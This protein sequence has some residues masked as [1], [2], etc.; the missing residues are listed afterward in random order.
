MKVRLR[1]LILG[2]V[3]LTALLLRIWGLRLSYCPVSFDRDE[4]ALVEK[5]DILSR[6]EILLSADLEYY[7]K[8]LAPHL[9]MYLIA[10]SGRVYST[11]RYLVLTLF[12][13]RPIAAFS[14]SGWFNLSLLISALAGAGSVYLVYL[15]GR[16]WG[17]D[18]NGLLSAL[19]F[20]VL[21]LHVEV[22]HM[23]RPHA[24]MVFFICLSAFFSLRIIQEG[25]GRDYLFS[26]LFGVLAAG[27]HYGATVVLAAGL[28]AHLE[29][30]RRDR[31]KFSRLILS[32][33]LAL[34]VGGALIGFLIA[35]PFLIDRFRYSLEMLPFYL[36]NVSGFGLP[37]PRFYRTGFNNLLDLGN[38]LALG[39]GK[40]GIVL[41]LLALFGLFR[42]CLRRKGGNS[43]LGSLV[44]L[45]L[46]VITFFLKKTD[47]AEAVILAPF[48]CLFAAGMALSA[49][50]RLIERRKFGFLLPAAAV[51]AIT[52]FLLGK[53]IQMDYF[54]WLPDTRLLAS[55][56]L[57][58]NIPPGSR[59]ALEDNI[60]GLTECG[61]EV[62]EFAAVHEAVLSGSRLRNYDFL[63]TSSF[64]SGHLI[65]KSGGWL[66]SFYRDLQ[67]NWPR[68]KVFRT[69]ETE[70]ANPV[71]TV[72]DFRDWGGDRSQALSI[73]R[74]FNFDYS[75][76][77]PNIVI[78]ADNLSRE[79]GSGFWI[80]EGEKINRLFIAPASLDLI[81]VGIFPTGIDE[82]LA[83]TV[84]GERKLIEVD[85]YEPKLFML[86][87]RVAFP[88]IDYSYRV[89]VELIS[90]RDALVKIITA[91]GQLARQNR[92]LKDPADS[93][94]YQAARRPPARF[95]GSWSRL[96]SIY[97]G[98]TNF[99][100]EL[101]WARRRYEF[102]REAEDGLRTTGEIIQDP[103]AAGNRAVGFFPDRHPSGYLLL[104]PGIHLPPRPWVATFRM[105]AANRSG[106]GNIAVIDVHIRNRRK[107][108][109]RRILTA[110][111]FPEQDRY[112]E[113]R[114]PFRNGYLNN[115][116]EF[117]VGFGEEQEVWCDRVVVSP[118]PVAWMEDYFS[119][120]EDKSSR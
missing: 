54:F 42:S 31:V 8:A 59:L 4:I 25:R 34:L 119:G 112:Y 115:L 17:G 10:L 70:N 99:I 85:D 73:L 75:A 29:N 35:F 89:R 72:Y 106:K 93:G 5:A 15:M 61:L 2:V 56:W 20:A 50:R 116:L 18:R 87:P 80:S 95:S 94:E 114:L 16:R 86:R 63:I 6:G 36:R 48:V 84:G 19:F 118:D 78:L 65:G 110:K 64:V 74:D 21:P 9:P 105:K 46:L 39:N 62:E 60:P 12:S 14:L 13:A 40:A 32:K 1:N 104:E 33:N 113:F 111:D 71:I 102:S 45:H 69:C 43:V 101:G 7:E 22:S 109:A 11:L 57:C 44:F 88:Y 83:V 117:R 68:W 67:Q 28:M 53:T 98:L 79:D 81:G 30:C 47:L 41:I 27:C 96:D 58:E 90:G 38:K 120:Q 37:G 24:L 23:V 51:I 49:S 92:L 66:G 103:A 100:R 3:L 55:R 76:A 82:T 52:A 77:S 108:L 107:T 26:G 97:S 91:P